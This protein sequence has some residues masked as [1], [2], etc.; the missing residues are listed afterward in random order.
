MEIIDTFSEA[1][2]KIAVVGK[3]SFFEVYRDAL[4]RAIRNFGFEAEGFSDINYDY[5]PDGFLI[6]NPLMYMD[7]KLDSKNYI[8]GAIQTEQIANENVYCMDQGYKNLY[9][10]NKVIAKYD[11]IF[12]WSRE[13]FLFLKKIHNNVFYFPHCF[14]NELVG[15]PTEVEEK[16]DIFFVGWAKGTDHRRARILEIL[17]AKYSMYPKFQSLW[18]QEKFHAMA[19]SRICLNLHYDHALV[20]ESPRIYEYLANNRFVLT[21]RILDSSP[22]VPGEDFAEFYLN[23]VIEKIDYYLES[24]EARYRIAENGHN[25][26][27]KLGIDDNIHLILE[28]F[29][30]KFIIRESTMKRIKYNLVVNN[31][32]LINPR[33]L[34]LLNRV[35]G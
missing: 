5:K 19:E 9:K 27:K 8:F 28:H 24:P 13:S 30:Q 22:F 4:V 33:L 20:F 31:K 11:F 12:E 21:E 34:R 10:L 1:Y 6:V 25:K 29:I 26:I 18:G 23:N 2:L 7:E 14:F 35:I 17:K 15:N 3:S 32:K 16:Y